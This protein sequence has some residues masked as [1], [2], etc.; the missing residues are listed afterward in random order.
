MKQS[1][2]CCSFTFKYNRIKA[3]AEKRSGPYFMGKARCKCGV[4]AVIT[5]PHGKEND[6]EFSV[7]YDGI[8]RHSLD[9]ELSRPI[10]NEAREVLRT[11]LAHVKPT[12]FFHQS[13]NAQSPGS[14]LAG[15]QDNFDTLSPL[16]KIRSESRNPH[17]A[18]IE[19]SYK[20]NLVELAQEMRKSDMHPPVGPS[21]HSSIH[22]SLSQSVCPS[23]RQSAPTLASHADILLA[24]H[25]ISPPCRWGG[26]RDDP[27][28]CLRGRLPARPFIHC[29]SFLE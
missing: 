18:S 15:N 4:N 28:Q 25:V 26:V 10:S 8:S 6:R 19:K 7:S 11:K 27:K 29:N 23:V 16:R 5:I 17:R 14:F 1:N 13:L 22:S 2:P 3:N 9:S 24:R 12:T 21:F 20:C